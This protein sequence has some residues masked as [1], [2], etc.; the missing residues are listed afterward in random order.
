MI[1][2]TLKKLNKQIII[3]LGLSVVNIIFAA[4]A[5]AFG[6]IFVIN[7]LLPIIRSGI[8]ES[9]SI[10]YII[11]GGCLAVIGFWWILP[12]A[13]IMDFITDLQI[14]SYK[15][16]EK[17]TDEKE[18][19]LII[20]LLSYYREND[21]KINRMIFIS[22]IGG[23]FFLINGVI[24]SVDVLSK[25]SVSFFPSMYAMQLAAIALMFGWGIVSLIIPRFL[26]QTAQ[27]WEYRVNKSEEA[28]KILRNHL[29]T[30]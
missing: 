6:V 26:K 1:N 29:E 7:H 14:E 4:I 8:I 11:A 18:I 30:T 22:R 28:A 17:S 5:L 21:R 20:R 13:S 3:F 15:E 23:S 2:I 12:S 27:I 10:G 24:S 25:I 19:E 16:K 9:I